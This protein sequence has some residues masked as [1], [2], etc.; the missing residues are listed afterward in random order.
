MTPEQWQRI[1]RILNLVTEQPTE[2]R[3]AFIRR[4]CEGEPPE[5][6]E[7]VLKFYAAM[8]EE[9]DETAFARPLNADPERIGPYAIEKRIGEGGMGVV[10]LATQPETNRQLAVKIVRSAYHSRLMAR[11]FLVEYQA[12]ARLNH[13]NIASIIEAGT[14]DGF[15]WFSMEYAPGSPMD[16]YCK[17]KQPSIKER[18]ALFLQVVS[19]VSHAHSKAIIHR[20]IKP[21]NVLVVETEQ[22]PRV[23]LIDF[24]IALP[25]SPNEERITATHQVIGTPAFMAPEQIT[26][27]LGI[28][29][30]ADVYALGT[31]LYVI[32]TGK[33]PFRGSENL[34]RSIREDDPPLPSTV[35]DQ[36]DALLINGDLD[37]ITLMAMRKNPVA[38]YQSAREFAADLERWQEG[39]PI[40]AVKQTKWYRARKFVARNKTP[41][42]SA[43]TIFLTVLIALLVSINRTKEAQ[44][45]AKRAE[46]VKAFLTDT[47]GQANPFE[48]N[49]DIT[50]TEAMDQAS[51]EVN[52]R[53]AEDVEIQADIHQALAETYLGRGALD[54][55]YHHAS[56]LKR[57]APGKGQKI[58]ADLITA[59]VLLE[60]GEHTQ[61]ET[62]CD[63]I[64]RATQANSGEHLKVSLYRA[65]AIRELARFEEAAAAAYDS[66]IPAFKS[67][68]GE[69][70]AFTLQAMR[71]LATTRLLQGQYEA[72]KTL[73]QQVLT[74]QQIEFGKEHPR[75]LETM[76]VLANT[77]HYLGQYNDALALLRSVL[78]T[79]ENVLGEGHSNTL[80]TRVSIMHTLYRATQYE[81]A[82]SFGEET[83]RLHHQYL[84]DE[85]QE[86]IKARNN[87]AL[88]Y[89]ALG[90]T[91]KAANLYQSTYDTQFRVFGAKDKLTL[92][93]G[94]N[95]GSFYITLGKF[96]EAESLLR[97]TWQARKTVYGAEHIRTLFTCFTLGECY[98]AMNR[99]NEALLLL[100][101]A[102]TGILT[103][104]AQDHEFS[105]IF[106]GYLGYV[107]CLL[108]NDPALLEFALMHFKGIEPKYQRKLN[109]FK[110]S[111]DPLLGREGD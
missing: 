29:T 75:T 42:F 13:P 55:A 5:F 92:S 85:A 8:E 2:D 89:E 107:R 17:E 6:L 99:Y 74:I 7:E 90:E 43:A 35:S 73:Y 24:G 84:G 36:S 10:F 76:N 97:E 3:P 88:I 62:L 11:R 111:C 101:E 83:V 71:G 54:R 110:E 81:E 93:Y 38:R 96:Q 48:G 79:R 80:K 70:D 82:C 34:T 86:T 52:T 39:Q 47:F 106:A 68:F 50:V 12:L 58:E 61:A 72:A 103:I 98:V 14:L 46:T 67:S 91:N 94:H 65:H 44:R 95:L 37:A 59:F 16:E 30:R 109:E 87:L 102:H 19:A 51:A 33:T 45:Q 66:I 40:T 56:E 63:S 1:Q 53:F 60:K 28:D 31:L 9:D 108:K 105:V 57:I 26:D 100:E 18:I 21:S 32:L 77:D 41:V 49:K 78:A 20:D 25:I 23:K 69:T 104:H 27:P 64:L 4:R 15:Q 22:G